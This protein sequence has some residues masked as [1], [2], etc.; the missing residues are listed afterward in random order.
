MIKWLTRVLSYVFLK[1]KPFQY[2]SCVDTCNI[3]C[4]SPVQLQYADTVCLLVKPSNKQTGN[5]LFFYQRG[6][7]PPP[8]KKS[9]VQFP[10]FS[11][12]KTGNPLEVWF[13]IAGGYPPLF[14]KKPN[15]FSFF[16]LK[17][18]LRMKCEKSAWRYLQSYQ[19][20]NECYPLK[21]FIRKK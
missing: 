19:A 7:T 18:S 11:S 1:S 3:C 6:G 5:S 20:Q 2:K 12:E 13:S 9:L 21:L 15:Y 8:K 10:V 4:S 14:G 17:A 16:L